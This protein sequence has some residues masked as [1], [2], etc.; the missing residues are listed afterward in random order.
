MVFSALLWIDTR[1]LMIILKLAKNIRNEWH[2]GAVFLAGRISSRRQTAFYQ[3]RKEVDSVK[4]ITRL[5]NR[6]CC[7]GGGT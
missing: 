1:P 3:F 2:K 4:R 6:S 5:L 7:S